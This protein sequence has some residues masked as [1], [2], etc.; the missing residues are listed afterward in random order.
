[1]QIN[2][3]EFCSSCSAGITSVGG[4][5]FL[6]VLLP[7]WTEDIVKALTLL[8]RFATSRRNTNPTIRTLNGCVQLIR[9]SAG[10][11][12]REFR[13]SRRLSIKSSEIYKQ[14]SG[15]SAKY[16]KWVA[17]FWTFLWTGRAPNMLNQVV[18]PMTTRWLLFY[19][20][21][22]SRS[23]WLDWTGQQKIYGPDSD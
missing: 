21:E 12:P 1:M 16:H 14:S 2:Q 17:V 6:F 15:L 13:W 23:D 4:N 19:G 20:E 9:E 3:T 18:M 11:R 8:M 7:V 5:D 22:A 10:K